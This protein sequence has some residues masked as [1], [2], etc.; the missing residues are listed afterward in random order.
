MLTKVL[1]IDLEAVFMT[2]L[3]LV[4]LYLILTRAA[5]LNT[6][7]K[8]TTGAAVQSLVVLQGR[9]PRTVLK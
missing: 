7:V 8:T 5:A 9:N 1:G 2:M 4:G 6:L 3:A